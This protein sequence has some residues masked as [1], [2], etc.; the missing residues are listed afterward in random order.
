MLFFHLSDLHIGAKLYD[1]DLLEDQRTVLTEIARLAEEHQPDA[2]VIA[3]DVYDRSIPSVE[4][5][6][7]LDDFLGMLRRG[8]PDAAILVISGNH[9]SPQRLDFFREELQGQKIWMIGNPP[10]C[11]GEKIERVALQDEYGAVNFYL[12]PFVRPGMVRPIVGAKDNGDNL[13]YAE[14]YRRL[15]ATAEVN[16]AERNVLVSHQFFLPDGGDA[17]SVER[18]ENEVKQVG[19]VDVI[20]SSV[21]SGFD[22]AALGHLHKPMKAGSETMRYCGTPMAYSLSEEGQEKGV[23]MV[24]LGE[25]G[26]VQVTSLPLHPPRLVRKIKGTK[27]EVTAGQSSDY[28]AVQL[29]DASA[30]EMTRLREILRQ[31]YP[32]MLELRRDVEEFALPEVSAE[33]LP[34][35]SPYELCMQFA[36]GRLKEEE[37]MLL[38]EI[39]NTLQ[40]ESL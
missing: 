8:V 23:L 13:S 1:R 26:N 29:T 6:A 12:L 21:I 14:A 36:A 22:Y 39:I 40:E 37:Q 4:A 17:D 18:A 19:N 32:N 33:A 30:E 7:L 20:P 25:K 28:V 27:Q 5:V 11:E 10:M 24:S 15:L 3:G 16:P 38:R 34:S 9:D 35:M 2:I 31:S